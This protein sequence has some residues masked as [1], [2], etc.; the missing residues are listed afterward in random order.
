MPE[1]LDE[2]IGEDNP[3]MVID[4]FVDSLDMKELN[5][6]RAVAAGMERLGY[7]PKDMLKLYLYN[8]M[9]RIRFL[10]R[11]EKESLRNIELM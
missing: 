8:Y 2:Y 3:I 9:N 5:F 6:K 4:A 7:L 1:C 10:R 11:M